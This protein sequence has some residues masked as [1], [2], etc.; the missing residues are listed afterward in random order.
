[1]PHAKTALITGSTRG[2]GKSLAE[3]FAKNDYNVVVCGTKEETA[4]EVA[5]SLGSDTLGVG[6]DV[7]N[8]EQVQSLFARALERFGRIDVVVNNAGVTRDGLLLRM[9]EKD[10][11]AVLDI[12][13]KGAFLV[14][15]AA[16]K[17]MLKQRFGR[18]INITSVI[19]LIGNP[20]QVNYSAAKAG[21]IGL[22][23]SAAKELGS[24]NITVN[25]I[26]P[27][28]IDTEMTAEMPEQAKQWLMSR[29]SVPRTGTVD[30]VAAAALF[31]AS[32]NASY[33]TG[34]VLAVDGGLT[35]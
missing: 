21:L 3:H 25:A 27:G 24:R 12:N 9:D 1:M 15:K 35:M 8:S 11:D 19:G 16:A 22:T 33:I 30:D 13:L 7:S 14:T 28:Y 20:G 32:D 4:N 10:W 6:V 5:R 17:V 23:R 2:I 34:Q 31:L 26:A 18:I 29:V